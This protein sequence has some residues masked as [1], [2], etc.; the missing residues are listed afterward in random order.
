MRML[1]ARYVIRLSFLGDRCRLYRQA[2]RRPLRPVRRSERSVDALGRELHDDRAEVVR[3]GGRDEAFP[4][5]MLEIAGDRR[6]VALGGPAGHEEAGPADDAVLEV[7]AV[8]LDR[9]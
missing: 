8:T 9:V 6:V 2:T 1:R 5:D 4:G 7:R 3:G